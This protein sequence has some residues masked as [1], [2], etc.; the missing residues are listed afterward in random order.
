MT[1]AG[2]ALLDLAITPFRTLNCEEVTVD[3]PAMEKL[4]KSILSCGGREGDKEREHCEFHALSLS[5]QLLLISLSDIKYV[6]CKGTHKDFSNY[7][8]RIFLKI[9]LKP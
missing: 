4:L 9:T 6:V 3:G 5:T 1:L 2:R 7:V 8:Q